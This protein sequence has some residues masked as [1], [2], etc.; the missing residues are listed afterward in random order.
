MTITPRDADGRIMPRP[1]GPDLGKPDNHPDA[2]GARRVP[3]SNTGSNTAVPASDAPRD[4]Q[5]P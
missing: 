4:E 3:S 1:P 5:Q 2:P